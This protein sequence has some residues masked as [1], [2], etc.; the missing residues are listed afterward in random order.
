MTALA[1]LIVVVL[2][3]GFALALVQPGDLGN[4]EETAGPPST[5]AAPATTSTTGAAPTTA[6]A[7]TPT[8]GPATTT[9]AA[10]TTMPAEVAGEATTTTAPGG[11]GLGAAG[12]GRTTGDN[13]AE[14][15]GSP[16]IGLGA[17]ALVAATALAAV[18]RRLDDDRDDD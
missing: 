11:S 10:P 15:G 5:R 9:A 4:G 18:S 2:V 17:L 3:A 12:A 7:P 8:T 14:T 13:L 1:A 6:A 16:P